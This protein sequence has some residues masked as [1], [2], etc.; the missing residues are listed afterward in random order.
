MIARY[1]RL[2]IGVASD[3][4]GCSIRSISIKDYLGNEIANKAGTYTVWGSTEPNYNGTS[5]AMALDNDVNT[6]WYIDPYF[7]DSRH[8]NWR[9]TGIADAVIWDFG[10]PVDVR[11]LQVVFRSSSRMHFECS[12][13][14]NI[15]FT[16]ARAGA[17]ITHYNS[18]P[19]NW[20]VAIP[21]TY[22]L[23]VQR[24]WGVKVIAH[25]PT[26]IKDVKIKNV[27][28]KDVAETQI[29]A[30][31]SRWSMFNYAPRDYYPPN[32]PRFFDTGTRNEIADP[33]NN[34]GVYVLQS[35]K[36]L[37]SEGRPRD[38]TYGTVWGDPAD[39]YNQHLG[40]MPMPIWNLQG[41]QDPPDKYGNIGVV[42]H[43]NDLSTCAPQANFDSIAVVFDNTCANKPTVVALGGSDTIQQESWGSTGGVIYQPYDMLDYVFIDNFTPYMTDGITISGLTTGAL[44]IN[45]EPFIPDTTPPITTPTPPA[46]YYNLPQTVVLVKNEPATIYYKLNGGATQVYTDPIY[47]ASDVLITYWGVDVKNNVETTKYAQYY[48][49]NVKPITTLTPGGGLYKDTQYVVLSSDK[50]GTISYRID[51]G[52]WQTYSNPITVSNQIT[53]IDYYCTD[54]YGNVEVMKSATYTI[55]RILPTTAISP[56]PGNY[57]E[58][59]DIILT[60]SEPSTTYYSLNDAAMVEYTAPI[61]VSSD[62]TLS[63]YSVDTAGNAEPVQHAVFGVNVQITTPS[64]LPGYFTHPVTVKLT[65]KLPG[66]IKHKLVTNR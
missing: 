27:I 51:G 62:C 34:I 52:N 20:N 6:I 1:W 40:A 60:P 19:L 29:E 47:I 39:T 66:T 48:I 41:S 63:Y 18:T 35:A 15:W 14:N 13:D 32:E 10:S 42:R 4:D 64:P 45:G 2:R 44:T 46:G 17:N 30:F 9:T 49:S 8:P 36:P 31:K 43:P 16:V 12:M 7:T 55:D 50:A 23:P 38:T 57:I 25:D 3:N 21:A 5:I 58:A 61:H 54:L 53:T 33:L 37:D 59:I 56:V 26:Q 11:N 24:F 22:S 28:M 65:S